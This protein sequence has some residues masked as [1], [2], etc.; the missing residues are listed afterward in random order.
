MEIISQI[1][2]VIVVAL[3]AIFV[4]GCGISSSLEMYPIHD[5]VENKTVKTENMPIVCY[6]KDCNRYGDK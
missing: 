1:I 6:F 3:L 2:A 4:S 5:R